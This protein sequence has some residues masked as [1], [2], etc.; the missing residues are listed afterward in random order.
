MA[1]PSATSVSMAGAIMRASSSPKRPF[2]PACGLRP[3]T[4]IRGSAIPKSWASA[5]ATIRARRV[6]SSC[7]SRP[8]TS[9]SAQWTVSGT[10][11][12][13]GP[14]SIITASSGASPQTS[15]RNSVCPGYSKPTLASCALPMGAV[16]RPADAPSR[17]YRVASASECSASAAPGSSGFPGVAATSS[18]PRTGIARLKTRAVFAGS[19]MTSIST[20]RPR[21]RAASAST[22]APPTTKKGAMPDS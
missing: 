3:H 10:A 17:Q 6:M 15:A 21:L 2:S 13:L 16:T 14:A 22:L 11:R 12:R 4:A 1:I 7:D 20:A 8:G 9:A 5:A 18:V 19:E